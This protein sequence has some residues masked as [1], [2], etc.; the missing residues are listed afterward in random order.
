MQRRHLVWPRPG[1]GRLLTNGIGVTWQV[2]GLVP[3]PSISTCARASCVRLEN[4]HP[5][6]GFPGLVGLALSSPWLPDFLQPPLPAVQ[7]W[8]ML[9]P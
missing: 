5:L 2:Q 4:T 1:P 9:A 7:R 6:P 8:A 3:G